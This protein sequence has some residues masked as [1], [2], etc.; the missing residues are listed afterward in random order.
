MPIILIWLESLHSC[1]SNDVAIVYLDSVNSSAFR[2]RKPNFVSQT[3]TVT[4]TSSHIIKSMYYLRTVI[5]VPTYSMYSMIL[6]SK[7]KCIPGESKKSLGVRR[8]ME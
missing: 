8:A 2:E 7:V 1:A 3:F 5:T 6:P 4:L